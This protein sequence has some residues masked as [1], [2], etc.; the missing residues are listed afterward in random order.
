MRPGVGT[1]LQSPNLNDQ[2]SIDRR[3]VTLERRLETT[4]HP[5]AQT[6]AVYASHAHASHAQGVGQGQT[7]RERERERERGARP[8]DTRR[9]PITGTGTGYQ[10]GASTSREMD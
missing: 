7:G 8:M 6:P 1:M 9:H 2:Y 3:I 10:Y 5:G 4:D